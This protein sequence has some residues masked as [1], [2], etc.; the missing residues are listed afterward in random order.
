MV[1]YLDLPF[2]FFQYAETFASVATGITV[3]LFD[4]VLNSG[5]FYICITLLSWLYTA[6]NPGS[7]EE[8]LEIQIIISK[9]SKS[10]IIF[11]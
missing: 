9:C 8:D 6:L 11:L 4:F 3:L 5:L 7:V 10:S 1:F 2:P